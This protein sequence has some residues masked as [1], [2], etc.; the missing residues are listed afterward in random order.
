[1]SDP[2][3]GLGATGGIAIFLREEGGRS[4]P[5]IPY[6]GLDPARFCPT[7]GRESRDGKDAMQ[8]SDFDFDLPEGLI[9][10]RPAR[11][12]SSAR[13]LV[14]EGDAIHD[15]V[16]TDLTDWLRP[17]DRLVLNDT[18]VIPARLK[19]KR[20]Q[21]GVEVTLHKHE[22]EGTWVA[23]VK[24]AKKLRLDDVITFE[25]DFTAVV[26]GKDGGEV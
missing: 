12:R 24:G 19:G 8:L 3:R 10:T 21:A 25:N 1:M 2:W 7:W 16:V 20:G 9:A 22:G 11:P 23:F 13:L 15:Q 17:G 14:A 18:R 4:D 5:P 6:P 26:L